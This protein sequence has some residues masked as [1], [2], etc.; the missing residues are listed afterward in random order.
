MENNIVERIVYLRTVIEC[1]R[2]FRSFKNDIEEFYRP[3]LMNGVDNKTSPNDIEK[4]KNR[5]AK[6]EKDLEQ[7]KKDCRSLN[8]SFN[9]SDAINHIQEIEDEERR[10]SKELAKNNAQN[11]DVF[12]D[13]WEDNKED[14]LPISMP[15]GQEKVANNE[16]HH[17]QQFSIDLKQSGGVI[18]NNPSYEFDE[19]LNRFISAFIIGLYKAF[20]LYAQR[21]SDSLK[22]VPGDTAPAALTVAFSCSTRNS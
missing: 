10:L 18:I 14:S 16:L 20:P 6:K 15:L 9:L 7:A 17:K 22:V 12:V 4:V 1:V 8:P 2:L 11:L 5:I 3:Q 19:K 21:Y 13:E